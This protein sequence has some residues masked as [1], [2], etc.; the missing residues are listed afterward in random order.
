MKVIRFLFIIFIFIVSLSCYNHTIILN[1]DKNSG[2]MIIEYNIDDD[3]FQLI[4]IAAE[5][6]NVEN[7]KK[8]DPL[9][10]IDEEFFKETFKETEYV[11]LKSVKIDTANG[12]KGTIVIEFKDLK[13]I[14][15]S[16]P[17]GLANL[18]LKKENDNVTLTQI[19][20]FKKMDPDGIFKSFVLQQKE[21]D[22][23]FYNRLTKQ[24]KFTFRIKT[25][26]PIKHTEGVILSKD[27]KEVIYTF[28]IN[29]FINNGKVLKFVITL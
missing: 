7:S 21:D 5:N 2:K 23:N 22:I 15:E 1:P 18:S 14:L 26:T 24:A 27:K 16:L 20:D 13:K 9:I 28:M 11:K 6:I 12:Y 10:L 8:F 25:A 17:A 4:S 19:L 3:Y 29:D